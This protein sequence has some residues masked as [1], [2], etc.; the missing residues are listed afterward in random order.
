M[1]STCQMTLQLRRTAL[2]D[3][4]C[5][6]LN[7]VNFANPSILLVLHYAYLILAAK[8]NREN[9]FYKLCRLKNVQ[10][11]KKQTCNMWS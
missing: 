9:E 8:S 10:I 2:R 6:H 3:C 11:D 1:E 7:T 4:C 5:Y